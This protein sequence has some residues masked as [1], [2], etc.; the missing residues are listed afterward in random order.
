L[1][2][3]I[4][5]IC[6]TA[7]DSPKIVFS[8]DSL[9]SAGLQ[10]E[11]WGGKI[12][13]L[14]DYCYVMASSSDALLSDMIVNE[15]QSKVSGSVPTIKEIADLFS[16]TCIN[17]KRKQQERDVLGPLGLSYDS[18]H[19][20]SKNMSPELVREIMN[21]LTYYRYKFETE[22]LIVGI[23]ML[24]NP[25]AHIYTVNHDGE[26]K[27]HDFLGFAVIGSGYTLAF[28]ELTKLAYSPFVTTWEE[29][30]IRVYDAKKVAERMAGVGPVTNL[31]VLNINVDEK[32]KIRKPVVWW[33]MQDTFKILDG[34]IEKL[35]K[36]DLDTMTIVH[37]ELK[38]LLAKAKAQA[39]KT[40]STTGESQKQDSEEQSKKPDSSKQPS[41]S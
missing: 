4:A 40:A 9:I 36:N 41:T 5:A 8:A 32:T 14:S 34:G 35:K 20:N 39:G 28:P 33:P 3:C 31:A 19:A 38:D 22:F 6:E 25:T 17:E 15:V 18:F 1:T 12:S 23:D 13:P 2:V 24:P 7:S 10:F 16:T 29:A 11:R 21:S 26:C 30:L 37:R 27:L